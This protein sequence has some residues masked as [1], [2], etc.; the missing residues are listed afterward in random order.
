MDLTQEEEE[1][2]DPAEELQGLVR[3]TLIDLLMIHFHLP[4]RL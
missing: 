2:E 3:W 4:D 1:A